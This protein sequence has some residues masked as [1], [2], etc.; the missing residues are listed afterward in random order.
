MTGGERPR[1]DS[2]HG[3]I[4][5]RSR[6]GCEVGT[7]GIPAQL[8]RRRGASYRCEPLPDGHQ[9]PWHYPATEP[10]SDRE[11]DS[12]RAAWHHLHAFGL[13]AVVPERVLAA[14]GSRVA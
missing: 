4:D 12:W 3:D 10:V 7:D 9:E 5:D 6:A 14:A 11:L 2:G 8:R 13:P 1:S